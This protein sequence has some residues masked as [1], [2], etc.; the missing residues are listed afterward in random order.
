MAALAL[1]GTAFA[2][3]LPVTSPENAGFSAGG[4]SNID[5]FFAQEIAANRIPGAVIAIA[6]DGKLV[7][8]EAYGYLDKEKGVPMPLDAIFGYASM[9]KIM[10]SVAALTLT[11]EGKLPLKSKLSSYFPAFAEMKVGVVGADGKLT[12]EPQ[13]RPLFIHDL[14]RHTSGLTYGGRG[15]HPISKLYPGGTDPAFEGSQLTSLTASLNCRW[16]INR[17]WHSNTAFRP[18]CWVQLWKRFRERV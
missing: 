18:M 1:N 8:Y 9:T 10:T 14:F 13:K 16:L 7:Y 3:P 12:L 4:L 11:Q 5:N 15:D 17:G 6:R 2:S